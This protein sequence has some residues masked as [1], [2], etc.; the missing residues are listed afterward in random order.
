MTY[1]CPTCGTADKH[2]FVICHHPACPDG[3]DQPRPFWINEAAHPPVLKYAP[4]RRDPRLLG[5]AV[6]GLLAALLGAFL[7]AVAF[8]KQA[9]GEE[10]DGYWQKMAAKYNCAWVAEKRKIYSDEELEKKAKRWRIPQ[11]LIELGKQCPR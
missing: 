6:T 11:S 9:R 4:R 5:M 3:R 1:E 8:P 7:L 10:P 2:Q